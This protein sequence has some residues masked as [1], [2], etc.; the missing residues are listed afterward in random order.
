MKR[1]FK[2]TS[3]CLNAL[4]LNWQQT[5]SLLRCA[6][7]EKAAASTWSLR[8]HILCLIW[9]LCELLLLLLFEFISRKCVP[10]CAARLPHCAGYTA[11]KTCAGC[12]RQIRPGWENRTQDTSKSGRLPVDA[13]CNCS[14]ILRMA[15]RSYPQV[16]R[17]WAHLT[18]K[19]CKQTEELVWMVLF[20]RCA[21]CQVF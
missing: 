16:L 10:K 17:K 20:C 19:L 9:Q 2:V 8:I 18:F 11:N 1:S 13:R 5:A 7:H 15:R 12:G 14:H 6:R 3:A 21:L 4:P